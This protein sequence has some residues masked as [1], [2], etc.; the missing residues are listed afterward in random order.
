LRRFVAL[1]ASLP[2]ESAFVRSVHGEQA[3]WGVQEHLLASAVDAL[4]VANWQRSRDGQ[5][6]R[7][8]PRPVPRP[9]D[10]APQRV[11]GTS[12]TQAEVRAALARLSGLD[13]SS[14]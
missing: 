1:V 7:R 3:A 12:R 11:G 13:P 14:S 2:P 6:G 8:A 10:P 4:N 9:T 5:T